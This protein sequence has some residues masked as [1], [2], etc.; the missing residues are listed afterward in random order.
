MDFTWAACL[1]EDVGARNHAIG[2]R[3]PEIEGLR[4]E[5]TPFA[6][7]RR[8]WLATYHTKPCCGAPDD[9]ECYGRCSSRNQEEE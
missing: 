2:R 5:D 7:A 6:R 4:A 9:Q 1:G 8:W 3:L